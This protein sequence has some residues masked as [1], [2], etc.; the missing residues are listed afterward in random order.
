MDDL[1]G[2]SIEQLRSLARNNRSNRDLV[3]RVVYHSNLV[4]MPATVPGEGDQQ[5]EQV[6]DGIDH[7]DGEINVEDLMDPKDHILVD[8]HDRI[9][10]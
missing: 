5:Q 4:P 10:F 3:R 7:E 2:I 9:I 1:D 6:D 8:R